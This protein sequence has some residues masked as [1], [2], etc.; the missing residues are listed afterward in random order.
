VT[1]DEFTSEMLAELRKEFFAQATAKRF[2]QEVDLLKKA[3]F[4]PASWMHRR[5]AKAGPEKYLQILRLIIRTIKR[6]GNLVRR[7]EIRSFGLYFYKC[8]QEHMNHHGDGYY[9]QAKCRPVADML[10]PAIRKLRDQDA[11]RTTE[12]LAEAHRTLAIRSGRKKAKS[13]ATALD[14]FDRC[15]TPARAIQ[16]G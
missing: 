14:L 12:A 1:A 5:G 2:F 15:K 8:V 6:N 10:D 4:Y 3:I 16:K 7:S 9:E 11:S 13:S